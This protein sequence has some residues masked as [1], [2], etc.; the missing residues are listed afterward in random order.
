M[1]RKDKII[2]IRSTEPPSLGAK[3]RQARQQK[4][5]TLTAMAERLKY[6]KSHLSAV[7]NGVGRPSQELVESYERAL[8]LEPGEFTR[9]SNGG[10]PALGHRHSPL[11]EN[12]Q[13][14]F[15]QVG[16]GEHEREGQQSGPRFHH[17]HDPADAKREA[18]E[19]HGTLRA[20]PL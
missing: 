3:L 8:E 7:E 10:A 2:S 12:G 16:Y 4:G 17:P 9:T 1:G 13:K 6:T 5:I 19:P 15:E 11:R 18:H 14:V 20:E